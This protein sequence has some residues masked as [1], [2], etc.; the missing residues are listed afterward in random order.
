M[1]QENDEQMGENTP[2]QT[3]RNNVDEQ[4]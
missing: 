3:K 4:S 1:T 2:H